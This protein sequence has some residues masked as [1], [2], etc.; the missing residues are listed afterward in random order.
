MMKNRVRTFEDKVITKFI[1]NGIPKE[2]THYSCIAAICIDSVIKLE[3]ENYP[4]VNFEQCKLKLKKK[5]TLIYLMI[6]QKIQV[7]NMN[8][9]LN[10]FSDFWFSRC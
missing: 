7:M 10:E 1:D 8:L 3:K 5:K 6:N 9:K 4:Q 2:N